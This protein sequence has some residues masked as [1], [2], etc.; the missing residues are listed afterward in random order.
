MSRVTIRNQTTGQENWSKRLR[1]DDGWQEAAAR[2]YR[3][4]TGREAFVALVEKPA[5]SLRIVQFGTH[6][7]FGGTDLSEKFCVY[8]EV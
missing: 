1:T 6:A 2:A 7:R 4:Q 3:N 5:E 8:L